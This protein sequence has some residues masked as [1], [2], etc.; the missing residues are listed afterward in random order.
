MSTH[1]CGAATELLI[2]GFNGYAYNA[3]DKMALHSIIKKLMNQN[4]D[5]YFMMSENSKSLASKINLTQ[6]AAQINSVN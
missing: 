1:Q 4:E 6:W 3:T 5:D 2:D